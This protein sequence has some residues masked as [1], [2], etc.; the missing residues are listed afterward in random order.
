M[1]ILQRCPICRSEAGYSYRAIGFLGL[2][3]IDW[4][5]LCTRDPSHAKAEGRTEE[6]A[7]T[8]WNSYFSND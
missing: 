4:E 6:Q 5:V 2:G 3:W 1:I 8:K 7:A